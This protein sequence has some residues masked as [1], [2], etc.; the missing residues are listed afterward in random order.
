[1]C[2]GTIP[3]WPKSVVFWFEVK[4]KL[5]SQSSRNVSLLD[6]WTIAKILAVTEVL[7]IFFKE[8]LVF[9]RVSR[10][11]IVG[12]SLLIFLLIISDNHLHD[13]WCSVNWGFYFF[14][15][16]FFSLKIAIRLRT[17]SVICRWNY[18]T[19]RDSVKLTSQN[20][21]FLPRVRTCA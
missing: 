18:E 10:P 5:F 14:L 16:L 19:I 9:T 2:C 7:R 4:G 13:Q 6:L 3:F 12:L 8:W 1:M 21:R 17:V 15:V 20:R 11:Y